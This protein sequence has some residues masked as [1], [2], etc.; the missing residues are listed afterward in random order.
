MAKRKD[1]PGGDMTTILLVVGG[2]AV[3]YWY[4][5]NFGPNG[6]VTNSAG[7]VVG[8]S[9]WQ[10]WFGGTGTATVA[11]ATTTTPTPT[12]T[13]TTP[14][15]LTGL[16]A[17][18]Q[19]LAGPSNTMLNVDQWNYYYYQLG[20][21][22]YSPAQSAA[23]A[24]AAGGDNPMTVTTYLAA[25][26]SAAV[27]AGAGSSTSGGAAPPP[28]TTPQSVMYSVLADTAFWS[29]VTAA[30]NNANMGGNAVVSGVV[31]NIKADLS[32]GSSGGSAPNL[33]PYAT[34]VTA[35]EQNI[36]ATVQGAIQVQV[37]TAAVGTGS[38]FPII[39]PLVPPFQGMAG[40]VPVG[41]T[42]PSGYGGLSAGA[43]KPIG[44]NFG[45][46]KPVNKWRN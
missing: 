1:N 38:P 33:T 3:L 44:M 9:W 20:N 34:S 22:S 12:T 36:L 42:R 19:S 25:V 24:A 30:I 45:G 21:P 31:A 39:D 23:I 8:Q 35:L 6:A 18:L 15:A 2:G 17:Q 27:G 41:A 16:A 43:G 5:N 29:T 11:G 14:T 13:N 26:Q 37:A 46:W 28:G 40:I 4:L 32:T 7:A 10:S